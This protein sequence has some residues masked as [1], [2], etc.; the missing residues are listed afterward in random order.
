MSLDIEYFSDSHDNT[1][2]DSR[3]LVTNGVPDGLETLTMTTPAK[4]KRKGK[5]DEN[6]IK[7]KG[8]TA[9]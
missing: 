2:L 7:F 5:A 9:P 4:K 8:D 1:V 3:I 6:E